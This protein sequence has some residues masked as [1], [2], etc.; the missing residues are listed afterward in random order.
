MLSFFLCLKRFI[1]YYININ[2]IVKGVFMLKKFLEENNIEVYNY[3]GIVIVYP[4]FEHLSQ[5]QSILES[6]DNTAFLLESKGLSAVMKDNHFEL[7]LS[8]FLKSN[9]IEL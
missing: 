4:N 6:I 5:L 1:W 7:D 3:K 9:N 8:D 2:N